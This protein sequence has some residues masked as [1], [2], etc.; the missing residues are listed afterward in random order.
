MSCLSWSLVVSCSDPA[1]R[2]GAWDNPPRD[3]MDSPFFDGIEWD[4]IYERRQDGPYVPEVP[5]FLQSRKSSV[6]KMSVASPCKDTVIGTTGEGLEA[7]ESKPVGNLLVFT[8][9]PYH[10]VNE[11]TREPVITPATYINEGKEEE[12]SSDEESDDEAVIPG[13]RD[14]V[15]ITSQGQNRLPDWSYIDEAVLAEYLTQEANG[16]LNNGEGAEG[17]AA[18]SKAE[19][20]KKKAKAAAE[21]AEGEAAAAAAAAPEEV[22]TT[23]NVVAEDVQSTAVAAPAASESVP[24]V[25]TEPATAVEDIAVAVPQADAVANDTSATPVDEEPI[26]STASEST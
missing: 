8:P 14:S 13:L 10:R 17:A 21:L 15:F 7:A 20:K 26:A 6:T 18:V 11:E 12:E 19:K 16:T 5:A 22:A 4:G 3:I 25:P 23:T 2:L 1:Q 9:P 24:D